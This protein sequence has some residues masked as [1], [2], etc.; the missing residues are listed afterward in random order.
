[1]PLKLVKV[2]LKISQFS[3]FQLQISYKIHAEWWQDLD[4]KED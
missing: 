2:G 3:N 4:K 1:M